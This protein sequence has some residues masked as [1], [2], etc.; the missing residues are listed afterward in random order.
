[1]FAGNLVQPMSSRR[2]GKPDR[3]PPGMSREGK[4]V[5]KAV[6]CALLAIAVV[7]GATASRAAVGVESLATKL[8]AIAEQTPGADLEESDED[9]ALDAMQALVQRESDP[10]A[11]EQAMASCH[12]RLSV[13]SRSCDGFCPIAFRYSIAIEFCIE[14]LGELKTKEAAETLVR[15]YFDEGYNWGAHTREEFYIA[16]CNL[17]E[18]GLP[19]LERQSDTGEIV[20]DLINS[21]RRGERCSH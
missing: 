1:M 12:D 2:P 13:V 17:G 16:I 18:V 21:V 3:P 7:V 11:F 4:Y 10:R 14:R 6:R 5:S 19:F 8:R 20:A 9:P 15:L